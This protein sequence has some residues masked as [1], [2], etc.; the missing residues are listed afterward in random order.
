M[1]LLKERHGDRVLPIGIGLLEAQAIAIP[2]QG[3]RPPRPMTHDVFAHVIADLGGHQQATDA[4][5]VDD[6]L[7]VS[8]GGSAVTL[9]RASS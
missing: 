4:W 5:I 9:K 2:L 8:L 3:V 1:L 6:R 7:T